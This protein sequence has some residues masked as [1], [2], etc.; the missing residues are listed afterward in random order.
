ME[1]IEPY[2]LT[3]INDEDKGSK[4]QAET[5]ALTVFVITAPYFDSMSSLLVN[6][7]DFC[8]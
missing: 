3:T 7:F 4:K 5:L 6:W 1:D 8:I 2:E